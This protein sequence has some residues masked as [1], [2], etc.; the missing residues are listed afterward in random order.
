MESLTLTIADFYTLFALIFGRE[1]FSK[2]FT[3]ESHPDLKESVKRKVN[4]I[5]EA[6]R[7]SLVQIEEQRKK[8]Q[9][10][11]EDDKSETD[12]SAVKLA[13][14]LELLGSKET[15]QIEKIPFSAIENISLSGNYQ[16]LYDQIFTEK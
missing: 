7:S 6:I 14:D 10:Y 3:N 1:T 5:G 13:K 12:L 2:G 9:E 15:I 11:K 4:K 8:I 16:Y